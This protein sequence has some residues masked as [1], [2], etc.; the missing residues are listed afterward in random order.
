MLPHSSEVDHS[1]FR[2][3]EQLMIFGSVLQKDNLGWSSPGIRKHIL[4][5][6][7]IIIIRLYNKDFAS[8]PFACMPQN[9]H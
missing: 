9:D 5:Y 7:C 6:C 1:L 4:G 3:E 8:R 2:A